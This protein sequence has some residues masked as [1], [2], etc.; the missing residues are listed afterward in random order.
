M[1]IR[2][3]LSSYIL[4]SMTALTLA[5]TLIVFFG[6]FVGYWILFTHFPETVSDSFLPSGID[7]L[8][9][10]LLLLPPLLIAIATS[11]TLAERILSPLASLAEA[12]KEIADGNLSARAESRPSTFK[13]VGR[14]VLDFNEMADR[15]QDAADS[16]SVWNAAVAH[17]IRTPLT[18]LKG[19]VQGLI[20]G[21][22]VADEK[23]LHGLMLQID[24]LS[25]LTDDL[26]TV[27]LADNGKL[28]LQIEPI[29]LS[30]EVVS[31]VDMLRPSLEQAGFVLELKLSPVMVHADAM[32]V[33]QAILAL[34]TNV[35]RHASPGP[36]Q[37]TVKSV[38]GSAVVSVEDC[39]PGL[40][41]DFIKRV[42]RP[43]MRAGGHR[44]R[45]PTGSGLGLAVVRAIASAHGG[46]V[47]YRSSKLGGSAFV[48]KVPFQRWQHDGK[49]RQ[50]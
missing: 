35:E 9:M 6:S 21:V 8:L 27:T 36:V 47:V 34:L 44:T 1:R 22:F 41:S 50:S 29:L 17:E 19:R 4:L 49:L 48:I 5:A 14:L 37:I 7:W 28:T 31:A 2:G 33:R 46:K 43:F 12:A 30:D 15:L 3:G 40:P 32:R 25:R 20:D 10:L 26:R 23:L 18:V 45:E 24:G 39:G 11:F 13:E 16:M 42:F 38:Q